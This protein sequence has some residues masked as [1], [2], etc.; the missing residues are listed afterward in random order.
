MWLAPTPRVS[1]LSAVSASAPERADP[2]P[3][4]ADQRVSIGIFCAALIIR[5]AYCSWAMP[6]YDSDRGGVD[7]FWSSDGY[8]ILAENLASDGRLAF[9]SNQPLTVF[10]TPVYPALLAA[11]QLLTGNV[12]VAVLLVN[13]AASSLTCVLV[14]GLA[15]RLWPG[16]SPGFAAA[17]VVFPLSIHFCAR[18]FDNTLITLMTTV[19]VVSAIRVIR[20]PQPRA[21][22]GAGLA[23][24]VATLTKPVM[25][26]FLLGFPLIVAIL[27]RPALRAA[28][29][30]SA[31]AI[32]AISPWTLRNY[33]VTGEFIPVS[34]GSAWNIIA[35]TFVAENGP[36][37][38]V[39]LQ[40]ASL[41]TRL[42]Y[43]RHYGRPMEPSLVRPLHFFDFPPQ[44]ER[45]FRPLVSGSMLTEPWRWVRKVVVNCARFWYFSSSEYNNWTSALINL[46]VLLFALLGLR[47]VERDRPLEVRWLLLFGLA[48][49][50]LYAAVM[51]HSTRYALPVLM[52]LTVPALVGVLGVGQ[53]IAAIAGYRRRSSKA[54]PLPGGA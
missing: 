19:F 33:R 1:P 42:E 20:S 14:F 10:R 41:Q 27:R 6:L 49:M 36:D 32:A 22:A 43:A 51:V 53:R 44:A 37:S 15:R 5:L 30:S 40:E 39:A 45:Q 7:F 12:A 23:L 34:T 48:Y 17:P 47:G 4:F 29:F 21:A 38:E 26:P 25:L 9:G 8:V 50:L 31:V 18:S 46:P 3:F 16:L 13:C 28:I 11:A 24:A 2:P 35:G 54:A 52:L